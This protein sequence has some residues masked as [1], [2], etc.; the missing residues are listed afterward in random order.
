LYFPLWNYSFLNIYLKTFTE[1]YEKRIF[2]PSLMKFTISIM[3]VLLCALNASGQE[4]LGWINKNAY[5]LQS[6]LDSTNNDLSFLSNELRGKSIFGLGEAS[7]GSREFYLQ[8][9]RIIEYLI[10]KCNFQMLSF[11][12]PQS[13]MV[14]INIFVQTGE[15]NL[16]ELMKHMGLYSTEEI[17]NLFQWI[18]GYNKDK[19]AEY[20]VVL[21]G[22]DSEDYWG[23]PYTRD[24]FMTENLIK[25]YEAKKRK[26]IVWTHN[27]HIMKD[28]TSN[29]LSMGS[30]LNQHFKNEFYALGFDTFKG[31][32][33]VL[34]EGEFESH[35][36]QAVASSFSNILA[37]AKD[38][39]FFLPFHKESPFTGTTTS[40]TNIYSNWQGPPKPLLIKPGIDFNGIVFIRET[41]PSIKLRQ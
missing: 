23:D 8:K 35:N 26:T 20:R 11:E 19:A 27:V 39:S 13:T 36:F 34:K 10:S 32:V 37:Q 9:A 18:R 2:N 40:I 31:T 1:G 3:F 33:N 5:E 21:S 7:H 28:T 15:G 16:K 24:K 41:S 38:K 12:S 4:S 6:D 29:S 22:L 17:Y 30:Y 25:S 14:P